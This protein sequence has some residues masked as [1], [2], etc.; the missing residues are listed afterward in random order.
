MNAMLQALRRQPAS[1]PALAWPGGT[2]SYGRLH[3]L[4]DRLSSMAD[5]A[6]P[7]E[8]PVAIDCSGRLHA[9]L[10]VLAALGAGR[11]ALVLDPARPELQS[12]RE[13]VAACGTLS[14][15][16]VIEALSAAA[17]GAGAGLDGG[18]TAPPPRDARAAALL[19]P[20]S[21][22]TGPARVAALSALALDAHA[23]ASAAVLPPLHPGDRWLACLPISSIGALAALWRCLSAG[24]AFGFLERF[25]AD[26]AR[27][28]L[29]EGASH[30]SVVPAMLAPLAASVA[31]APGGLRCLLSGGGPLSRRA[32][33]TV[34]A[35]GW[36]LWNSWGMTETCS[37][38]AACP[39]DA[40]WSEGIVGTPLPGVRIDVDGPSGRLCV[41]GPVL[42]SGYAG[43]SIPPGS[44]LAADGSFLSSDLGKVLEDGRVRVAGRAD[45]VIVSGGV[46]IHPQGVEDALV[47][48]PRAGEVAITARPDDRWGSVLVALYTG[49]AEPEQLAAWARE[50][51]PSASRP[52]EFRR[53]PELPR[54]TMGKLL[55]AR[56]ATLP[57]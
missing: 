15:V 8:C 26:A 19:V 9:I 47:S 22:T 51:L 1:M 30:V 32:A 37:H 24:A 53:V 50:N 42:M 20:T 3:T 28:F 23:A 13:A 43:G 57:D 38:V 39:V 44:G 52:R 33:E 48:C 18:S 10:G 54:N 29:A 36:P 14:D 2:L 46:N 16:H 34:L 21:G 35:Q 56:L 49:D 45:E 27:A 6:G 25:E 11:P 5:W 4:L 7:A 55:R 17:R 41:T 40:R 12:A 31:P